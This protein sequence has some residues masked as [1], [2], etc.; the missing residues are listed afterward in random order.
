[1]IAITLLHILVGFL[2]SVITNIKSI[3]SVIKKLIIKCKYK[4]TKKYIEKIEIQN[5]T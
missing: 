4:P 1:M 5:E 2:I 3:I